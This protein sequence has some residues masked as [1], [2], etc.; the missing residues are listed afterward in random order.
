M[1]NA[2]ILIFLGMTM[3]EQTVTADLACE[4]H[5]AVEATSW[6]VTSEGLR[7]SYSDGSSVLYHEDGTI[8]TK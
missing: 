7:Y 1:I 6:M 2:V 3:A 5:P 8:E 4:L